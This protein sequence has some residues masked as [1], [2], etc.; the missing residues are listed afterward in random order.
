MYR[1][2]LRPNKDTATVDEVYMN[3]ESENEGTESDYFPSE[4]DSETSSEENGSESDVSIAVQGNSSRRND[5]QKRFA[6]TQGN[7]RPIVHNFD[8]EMSGMLV[9]DVSENSCPR[10]YFELVF[11]PDMLGKIAAET[12]RYA[13]EN[14]CLTEPATSKQKPWSDTDWE[15]MYL[16]LAVS[17]LFTRQK[18]LSVR[19]LVSRPPHTYT[20]I[21]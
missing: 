8:N 6:W 3:D 15:E 11:S 2:K 12:N 10:E 7:F 21:W 5:Q 19:V 18:K 17:M 16:F 13:H 14:I 4:S 20:D 1:R 9:D